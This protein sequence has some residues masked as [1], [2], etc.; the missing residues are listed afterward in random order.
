MVKVLTSQDKLETFVF[1]G[2]SKAKKSQLALLFPLNEVEIELQKS[3]KS[4]LFAI[5]SV[6]PI[7]ARTNI[8][9][10]MEQTAV[11]FFLAEIVSKSMEE[12]DAHEGLFHFVASSTEYFEHEY[13]ANFHLLFLLRLTRYLGIEPSMDVN[14]KHQ[15]FFDLREGQ[16]TILRPV[17]LHY[18]DSS[19]S[20]LLFK[21]M[22]DGFEFKL[23]LDNI[24][25]G[26]LLSAILKY[27]T[28]HI[29]RVGKLKSLSVLQEL[30]L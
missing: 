6:R 9:G 18:L 21:L 5:K 12:N 15:F 23:K 4:K 14:V 22:E 20:K 8:R 2:S 26:S 24:Q 10:R 7:K 11:A 16:F 30:F 1:Q 19:E 27:Y 3:P 13:Q 29:D 25:R 17:H 28:Y